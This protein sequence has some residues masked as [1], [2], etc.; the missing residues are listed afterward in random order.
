MTELL[1]DG[2][3][4]EIGV[5]SNEWCAQYGG[6]TLVPGMYFVPLQ[7]DTKGM[8]KIRATFM[9]G[10]PWQASTSAWLDQTVAGAPTTTYIDV[11]PVS[12]G[13]PIEIT[14]SVAGSADSM[15]G[16]IAC[17]VTTLGRIVWPR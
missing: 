16:S 2:G 10:D 17:A 9:P 7:F 15:S 13:K 14:A 5:A 11:D 4:V 1:S 12:A 8:H 3:E 6:A